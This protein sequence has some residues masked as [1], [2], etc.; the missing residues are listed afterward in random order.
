MKSS[1]RMLKKTIP[2]ENIGYNAVELVFIGGYVDGII[3]VGER[4]FLC[5]DNE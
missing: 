5:P 1:V 4:S 3:R 2:V